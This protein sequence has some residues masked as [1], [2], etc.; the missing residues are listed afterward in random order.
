MILPP[1]ILFTSSYLANLS[2][3]N[4]F[5]ESKIIESNSILFFTLSPFVLYLESSIKLSF[6]ITLQNLLN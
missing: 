2:A 3:S 4:S 5:N 1:G 6:P